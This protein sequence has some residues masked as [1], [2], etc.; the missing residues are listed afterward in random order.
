MIGA[1]AS[2]DRFDAL[3]AKALPDRLAVV[4]PVRVD[5]VGV[6]PWPSGHTADLRE[7]FD[8]RQNQFVVTGVGRGGM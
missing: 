7:V 8:H 3:R 2:D 5:H 1:S 6:L 4:A